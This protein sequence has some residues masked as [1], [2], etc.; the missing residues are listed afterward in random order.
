MRC[1]RWARVP[2]TLISNDPDAVVAFQRAVKDVI[3]KPIT[4]GAITRALDEETLDNLEHLRASPVIFQERI[5]GDDLR[6]M[7]A[8]DD[9]VSSVEI[10]TPEQRLDFRADPVYSGGEATCEEV[11]L[12]EAVQA[13]CREAA[14]KCGLVFAGIDIKRAPSGE[15]VFLEINSSPIYLDVELKLGHPISRAITELVVGKR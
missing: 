9:I 3:S 5:G 8:G 12:P 15:W 11:A 13:K 7:L 4:G 14:R 2:R 10:R 6:V 1:A